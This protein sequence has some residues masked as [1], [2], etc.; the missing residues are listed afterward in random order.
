VLGEIPKN[1]TGKFA[2][3]ALRARF[4]EWRPEP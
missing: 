2:K 1:A 3:R 4:A